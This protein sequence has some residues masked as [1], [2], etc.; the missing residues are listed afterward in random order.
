MSKSIVTSELSDILKTLRTQNKIQAKDVAKHINKSPAYITKLEKAEFKTIDSNEL[1]SI[2]HYITLAKTDST[3]VEEIYKSLKFK[4]SDAEI[5]AQI[6]FKNLD[7]ITR[8]IPVPDILIDNINKKLKENNI[9]RSYLC[10]RINANEELSD[11]DKSSTSIGNNQWFFS[12]DENNYSKYSIKMHISEDQLNSLLNQ[13]TGLSSYMFIFC[14]L[15]YTNKI[16]QYNDIVKLDDSSFRKLHDITISELNSYKVFS[17][18]TYNR[19]YFAHKSTKSNDYFYKL[20]SSFDPENLNYVKSILKEFSAASQ[21]NFE[22]T[23]EKLAHFSKNL[24]WDLGFMLK[25]VSMDYT[26][27]NE[28]SVS[29]KKALLE[30]ITKVIERYK[31]LP[32]SQNMIEEY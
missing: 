5:D 6:W 9:T 3:T 23:S 30:D 8:K 17:I 31:E 11:I 19:N 13:Q 27:L 16:I 14:I 32:S 18:T 2:L 12:K 28:I 29:N 15:F 10:S 26:E 24:E 22:Y 25:I 7:T 4:Y 1:S 21:Y 20:L